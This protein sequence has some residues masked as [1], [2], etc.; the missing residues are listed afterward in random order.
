MT[1]VLEFLNVSRSFKRGV[2]V[3]DGVTFSMN[4]GEVVGLLGRNGAGKTTLIHIAMG[5]LS[6]HGGAVRVFGISPFDDPAAIKRR[7]GWL[8]T[9]LDN[10]Y[11][12]D[13][14][15]EN[16]LA[17]AARGIGTGLWKGGDQGVIDG[18]AVNGSARL[19]AWFAGVIR[20]VQTGYIYHYA[21]AM[22]IGVFVLMTWFVWLQR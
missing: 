6:M 13:W 21:F 8:Y 14:F 15:N 20:W 4:E 2:P 18:V 17:R 19:V 3:L 16:V 7:S 9:I 5:L 22:I 10:K 11:Y 1:P 12:F